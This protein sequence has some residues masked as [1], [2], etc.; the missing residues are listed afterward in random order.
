LDYFQDRYKQEAG[1]D[2]NLRK[3]NAVQAADDSENSDADVADKQKNL[4]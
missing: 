3:S 4:D 1:N 2:G